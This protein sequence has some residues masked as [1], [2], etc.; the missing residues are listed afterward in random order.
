MFCPNCGN[1]IEDNAKF[2][3][4]CGNSVS[5]TS[6][7]N[8]LGNSADNDSVSNQNQI[9]KTKYA[10]T[11]FWCSILAVPLCCCGIGLFLGI[12]SVIFGALAIKNKEADSAKAWI[13]MILGVFEIFFA[14]ILIFAMFNQNT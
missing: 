4:L 6:H 13:G 7:T 11:S 10:E 9:N 3:N 14:V 5:G 1:K 8:L 12:P 2:C